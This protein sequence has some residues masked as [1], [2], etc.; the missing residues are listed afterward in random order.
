M[1]NL[2][3]RPIPLLDPLRCFPEDPELWSLSSTTFSHP[4][5]WTGMV[6]LITTGSGPLNWLGGK[7][8]K[9]GAKGRNTVVEWIGWVCRKHTEN[10]NPRAHLINVPRSHLIQLISYTNKLHSKCKMFSFQEPSLRCNKH[11]LFFFTI[12]ATSFFS[13]HKLDSRSSPKSFIIWDCWCINARSIWS[14]SWKIKGKGLWMTVNRGCGEKMKGPG[15]RLGF[16]GS[17]GG[18]IRNMGIRW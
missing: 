11:S 12:R 3:L 18:E 13:F 1:P 17:G 4:C 16:S 2:G 14:S 5:I 15:H 7:K 10:V 6:S 9:G 8:N